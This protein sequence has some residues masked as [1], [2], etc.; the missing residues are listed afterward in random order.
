MAKN[1]TPIIILNYKTYLESTGNNANPDDSTKKV[2]SRLDVVTPSEV[3]AD[4]SQKV[5]FIPPTG[6]NKDYTLFTFIVVGAATIIALGFIL[7]K[8]LI[9]A[10]EAASSKSEKTEKGAKV[11]KATTTKKSKAKKTTS[12]KSKK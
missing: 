10:K 4:S 6:E 5:T 8:R 12:K 7:T 2:Y 11:H 9:L 1:K 3:D